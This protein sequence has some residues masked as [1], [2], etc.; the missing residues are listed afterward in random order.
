VKK[1]V[2]FVSLLVF[3]S[4][5]L[6]SCNGGN[7]PAPKTDDEKTLYTMGVMLGTNL[8]RLNLSKDELNVL[9]GGIEASAKGEQ[10]A[11]KVEEFQGKIQALVMGRMKQASEA[12]KKDGDNFREDFLKKNP[13][14]KKTESG[15]IYLV[16][17][18]GGKKPIATDNVKVHYHGTLINGEVFDSSKDRGQPAEF[19]LNRVIKGWTEGMQ[20]VG[21]G[22]KIKLVIPPELGYGERGAGKIPG[23]ATLVFD[24]ELLEIQAA[25][26]PQE[27][28]KAP[29]KPSKKAKK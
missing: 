18:E 7:K 2:T 25:E 6:V 29:K 3:A 4:F 26:A 11:V 10:P 24:V 13:N 16:E 19:P 21:I 23:G 17:K 20:L 27:V 14:A 1:I 9:M 5:M 22:G 8:Q 28:A 12:S 15:L